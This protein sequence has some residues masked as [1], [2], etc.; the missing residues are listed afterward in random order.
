MK[1]EGCDDAAQP[2]GVLRAGGG[3]RLFGRRRHGALVL[4]A[5]RVDGRV[6]LR[7]V[8]AAV[9]GSRLVADRLH[10]RT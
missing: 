3:G 1:C 6:K 8:E 5:Q 7:G 9:L 10:A 2:E 4:L